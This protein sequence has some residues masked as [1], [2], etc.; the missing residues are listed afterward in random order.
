MFSTKT[1]ASTTLSDELYAA[2]KTPEF[3]ANALKLQGFFNTNLAA[4]EKAYFAA[5]SAGG[6]Q[7][8]GS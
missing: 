5:T 7:H 3:A 1:A 4:F 8:S 6:K 2:T